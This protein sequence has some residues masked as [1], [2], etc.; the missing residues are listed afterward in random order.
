MI[1]KVLLTP[2]P[3][4]FA[5][6]LLLCACQSTPEQPGC[7]LPEGTN[8]DRALTHARTDLSQPECQ[9]RFDGYLQR[10]LEIAAGDPDPKHS[11]RFSE[12]LI[13]AN[14][15]GVIT[16]LKA[17]EYYNRY[18]NAKFVSLPDD[19][20]NC[21]YTCRVQDEITAKMEAELRDKEFG[22]LKVTK[23]KR[24]FAQA[25]TLYQSMLTLIAATCEACNTAP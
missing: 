10:L 20:S 7:N 13:W 22:L 6:L 21:A 19:Y 12:F 11:E 8:L 24:K 25:N 5:L 23:D 1:D 2:M 18:F 14:D 16:K 4:A 3:W 17:K 9:F 15:Q